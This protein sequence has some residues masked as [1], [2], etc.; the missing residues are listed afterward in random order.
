MQSRSFLLEPLCTE[1]FSPLKSSF[2]TEIYI[3][4]MCPLIFF[5]SLSCISLAFLFRNFFLLLLF[6]FSLL[7]SKEF[8]IFAGV[9]HWTCVVLVGAATVL[10]GFSVECFIWHKELWD[11]IFSWKFTFFWLNLLDSQFGGT[12]EHFCAKVIWKFDRFTT[13]IY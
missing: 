3:E 8:Q 9:K 7:L 5:P 6:F 13:K 11:E 1:Y 12:Y 4:K 10:M 2:S